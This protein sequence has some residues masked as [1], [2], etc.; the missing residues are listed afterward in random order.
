MAKER[1]KHLQSYQYLLRK[2]L[3]I[4]KLAVLQI[5]VFF[6]HVVRNQNEAVYV[7]IMMCNEFKQN[8]SVSVV[9]FV[10]RCLNIKDIQ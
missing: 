8:L 9:N 2:M 6:Q 5:N 1:Q 3:E 4:T 7:G 10:Q